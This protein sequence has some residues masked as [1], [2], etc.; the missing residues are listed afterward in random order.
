[1]K[2]ACLYLLLLFVSFSSRSQN[3]TS[4]IVSSNRMDSID[5]YRIMD[6]MDV[7]Y[8]RYSLTGKFK[9]YY[10]NLI[11]QEYKEGK[12][13]DTI[14]FRDQLPLFLQNLLSIGGNLKRGKFDIGI[15]S[16]VI[17]DTSLKVSAIIGGAGFRPR[18]RL[19]PE[20]SYTWKDVYQL[21]GSKH[22]LKPEE[23]F[24]LAAYTSPVG[25]KFAIHP[26]T[27]EFCNITGEFIP[28]PAWYEK[29]GVEHYFIF[30]IKL[31]KSQN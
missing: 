21:P 31:E 8:N 13:I 23:L 20:K 16:Q 14:S 11:I 6:L 12:C 19:D 22:P 7:A 5:L 17:A 9:D 1:M 3:T 30:F 25:Q 18:L 27:I 24:P 10:C 28:Y 2:K 29:L 4:D 26:N 15:Y